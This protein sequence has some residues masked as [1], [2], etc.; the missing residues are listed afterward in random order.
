MPEGLIKSVRR[1]DVGAV[2]DAVRTPQGYLRCDGRITRV[3]VFHYR[4]GAGK[5]RRELRLPEEVFN[6]DA[7]QSF[8]LAPLTN[9]HP[10]EALS[11]KN[12]GKYQVGTIVSPHVDGEFVASQ[13][14]ITDERAIDD[15]MA[16]KRELSCG[17]T[18]DLEER[19][20]VTDGI[21]GVPDGLRY[22]GIQRNI[23]GNHVAIVS[24]GRAGPGASLILDHSDAAM[25]EPTTEQPKPRATPEGEPVP[26]TKIKI[27]GVEYE[28]SETA[29]Q[30]IAKHQKSTEEIKAELIEARNTAETERA[31]AD[32]AEEDLEVER[33]AR[34]DAESPDKIRERIDQRLELERKAAPILGE[35][36]KLDGM[37]DAEIKCSVVIASAKDPEAV[38]AKLEGATDA[39]LEARYDAAIE[40]AASSADEPNG[41]LA[42]LKRNTSRRADVE[43]GRTKM[44]AGLKDQWKEPT[45]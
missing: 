24:A 42:D 7:M 17:Y 12:T 3:G 20:G 35:E 22:D 33:K 41:G 15:V 19:P 30:A 26:M 37:A 38:K 43:D 16:G 9:D 4:D 11:A 13:I 34:A 6:S 45:Q 39:Y 14:Q 21:E 29:A 27:D 25:V 40:T 28:V 2:G 44:I 36:V 10:G 32:K 23:R 5:T 18:A 8:A 1:W 31:R